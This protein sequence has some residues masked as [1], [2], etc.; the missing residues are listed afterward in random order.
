MTTTISENGEFADD[1]ESDIAPY[2]QAG[3]AEFY[4]I[5]V[6]FFFAGFS[7]FVLIY[8]VQPLLP[9]FAEHYHVMA[10]T[11]SL[12][13]S[14]TLGCLACSIMVMGA[15]SQQIGRKNLMLFSMFSAAIL[16]LIASIAPDWNTLL[17]ARAL[18]GFSLGGLPAV[19]MAYL[20]EEIERKDLP[21]AMGI[22][23][24]GTAFGA[25]L[26]RVGMGTLT[27]FVTWQ[28]AMEILGVLCLISACAFAFLLPPSR[29]FHKTRNVG[30]RFHLQTWL[31]H[32]KNPSLQ[33]VYALGF[34]LIGVFSTI[35]NYLSFRLFAEPY[36]MGPFQVSLIFLLFLLGTVS[37]SYT[38]AFIN[39]IGSKPLLIVSFLFIFFGVLITQAEPLFLICVGI[40]MTTIGFFVGHSVA[41]GLVGL[42]AKGN[43][44]HASSLYLLFYYMGA[45]IIGYLGGWF[46]HFGRWPGLSILTC[47]ISLLAVYI[48]AR[49]K[50]SR[51]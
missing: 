7:T 46:W 20:A 14:L 13:L 21:K 9:L 36:N 1:Y 33:R 2:V 3:S 42:L 27:E 32:L 37:S 50:I 17:L 28:Q 44:G 26:G 10:A 11:S 24:A 47:A 16:N 31:G 38:G 41:S 22:Y 23:I 49:L 43:N 51:T 15:L 4:R 48:S 45:S 25:M 12:P 6:S 35:Y 19:A 39:R 29:H 18:E 5:A 30:V 8:C 34:C 40:A